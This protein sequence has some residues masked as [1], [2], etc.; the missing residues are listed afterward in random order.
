MRVCSKSVERVPSVSPKEYRLH[1]QGPMQLLWLRQSPAVFELAVRQP[2]TLMSTLRKNDGATTSSIHLVD[3][4]AKGR[5]L[6]KV[7][8]S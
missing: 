4:L 7:L 6:D 2:G 3:E 8:R 5:P 1:R